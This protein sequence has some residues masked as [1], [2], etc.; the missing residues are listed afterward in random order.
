MK[1]KSFKWYKRELDIIFSQ[2]IRLRDANKDGVCRCCTC[3]TPY[4]W[5]NTSKLNC[6]HFIQRQHMAFRWDERNCHAQCIT[7]NKWGEGK[8]DQYAAFIERQY[9]REVLAHFRTALK[10][11][12]WGRFELATLL[13]YYQD[14]FNILCDQKPGAIL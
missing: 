4:S 8:H 6:G 2:Y 9:G 5:Y 12:K 7:C 11:R 3:S 1:I 10:T 14:K 13:K